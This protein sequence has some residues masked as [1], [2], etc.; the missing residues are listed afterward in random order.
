MITRD[1]LEEYANKLKQS[2]KGIG[3]LAQEI[4]L[5]HKELKRYRKYAII[6]LVILWI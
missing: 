2:T 1:K 4:K 6:Y 5:P 3:D